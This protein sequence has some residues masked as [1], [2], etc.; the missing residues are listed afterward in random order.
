MYTERSRRN[1][2][3]VHSDLQRVF[4]ETPVVAGYEMCV[5]EGLRSVERQVELLKKGASTTSNSRHFGPVGHA[6][7]FA[8]FSEGEFIKTVNPAYRKQWHAFARTA[9]RLGIDAEWGGDWASIEDGTHV[10]LSWAAYPL[11]KN[12][13]TEKNSK[14]IAAAASVPIVT[15]LPDIV[16]AFESVVGK[17]SFL[18]E[19]SLD[20]TRVGLALLIAAF[21]INE[22]FKNIKREGV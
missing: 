5:T 2:E 14:T 10:Q 1:L 9:K 12:P 21:I 22:R 17:F 16:G 4:W 6:F 8:M 11:Q 18:S 15:I 20:V 7:D 19:T 3:G 13:K